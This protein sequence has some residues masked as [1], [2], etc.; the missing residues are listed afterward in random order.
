MSRDSDPLLERIKQITAR[1]DRVQYDREKRHAA[2]A[3]GTVEREAVSFHKFFYQFSQVI[4]WG[5][6][7]LVYPL[8]RPLYRSVTWILSWYI[9]LW[10]RIVHVPDQYGNPCFSKA[11]AIPFVGATLAF[12][13][14]LP[15]MG[16]T[17]LY[18]GTVKREIVYLNNSQEILPIEGVH[19][20][21]GC[22]RLP[23]TE[24]DA[25]YFRIR[26]TLF[27]E[28]W[29]LLHHRT[30]FYSDY[31]AAAVPPVVSKC[32]AVTYGV[33]VKLFVRGLNI[34]PDLIDVSCQP[35]MNK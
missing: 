19:S 34:Y 11:R 1:A 4:G 21:Q 20:V 32:E 8:W 27:N 13:L 28:V 24:G 25:I 6:R 16:D 10:N 30:W 33:R 17:F 7:S 2:S 15:M 35:L 31:V 22:Q 23:C 26:P 5:L 18:F 3:I 14:L 12:V 29:S 9:R